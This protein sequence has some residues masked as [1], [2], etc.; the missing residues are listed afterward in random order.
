VSKCER[1]K[2]ETDVVYFMLFAADCDTVDVV[3]SKWTSCCSNCPVL[4]TFFCI[5]YYCKTLNVNVN[6]SGNVVKLTKHLE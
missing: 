3:S 4:M 2:S 5:C 6:R 1:A